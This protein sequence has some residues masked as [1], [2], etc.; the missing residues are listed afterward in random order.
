MLQTACQQNTNQDQ[1]IVDIAPL[2]P[3]MFGRDLVEQVKADA[4]GTDRA[5]PVIV[6]KCI[7]AVETLAMDYEGIYRKTGGTG[8]SKVITQLFEKG[9]YD[10]FDL[11]DTDA[12]NDICSVTSVLKNYFRALPNPLLTYALHDAFVGASSLRDP[13]EKTAALATL[14][15]QLP[16]EHYYTLKALMV[17]LYNVQRQSEEN[18]MNARNL[19]VVFGPTLMRSNDPSK[20]FADMAGKALSVEWLVEHAPEVFNDTSE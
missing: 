19:G 12:F 18:L 11:R 8:Q 15:R 9:N 17:H 7:E 4:R 6:E 10:A 14:V 13:S 2:P 5:I 3:S 1:V 20:E 16:R